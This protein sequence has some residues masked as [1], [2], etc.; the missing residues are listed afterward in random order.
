MKEKKVNLWSATKRINAFIFKCCP[1]YYLSM[2]LFMIIQSLLFAS[3]IF[4][5]QFVFDRV[6]ELSHGQRTIWEA[7]IA[8]SIF[9][10]VLAAT[11]ITNGIVNFKYSIISNWMHGFMCKMVAKKTAKLDP[12]LFEDPKTLDEINKAQGATYLASWIGMNMTLMVIFYVPYFFVIIFYL[13]QLNPLLVWSIA[14]AFIPKLIAM[15]TKMP[16]YS[17]LEDKSAPIRREY[18]FYEQAMIDRQFFKETRILGAFDYF[19]QKYLQTLKLLNRE[20]WRTDS[21]SAT[22]D[23]TMSLMTVVGYLGILY[24]LFISLQNGI[25]TIGAFA[26]VFGSIASLIWMM[27]EI[28][29]WNLGYIMEG[30]GRLSYLIR[31]FDLPEKTGEEREVN[32]T[33][34]IEINNVSFTYPNAATESLRSLTLTI[35][36]GETIAIVGEN[37]AGKS[38]L[39]KVLMGIYEPTEGDITVSGVKIEDV[40]NVSR[41]KGISAV[42][43]KFQ[44]YQLTLKENIEISDIHVNQE[45]IP[46]MEQA[47]VEFDSKTY[48]NG[49][50]TILSREF[51]GVD[52]S[53]GQWQR[54][55]IARGLYRSHDL[56]I[57]DEPTAAIDPIEESRL[58]EMFTKLA[59]SKTAI[60]VTHRL[61][62]A[63]LADRIL[64]MEDGRIAEEGTHQDLMARNG[65]YAKMFKSQEQW[66]MS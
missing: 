6:T 47:G 29:V 23:L 18:E 39:T 25:I 9:A 63:Q 33:G 49:I 30:M 24:L 27:E 44:R 35:K 28:L 48:P 54:I 46:V 38:T 37:G 65:L 8:I 14:L 42:F 51:D 52:L 53:G 15:L 13:Y 55:A 61:A 16:L 62:S 7:I 11:E 22:I 21:K 12:I 17:K 26:A 32:W 40:A 1:R 10:F 4:V 64:V 5:T 20:T 56:I 58:Y 45:I 50:E 43:Q 34:D 31:F 60:I 57:L 3:T 59:K 2:C 66:Y 36:S 19:K 41:F